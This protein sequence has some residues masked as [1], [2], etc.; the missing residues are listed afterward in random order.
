M[1]YRQQFYFFF[2][3]S[4]PHYRCSHRYFIASLLTILPVIVIV[5]VVVLVVLLIKPKR[6]ITQ[7]KVMRD[8]TTKE[9]T[10]RNPNKNLLMRSF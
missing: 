6:T 10:K 9:S 1:I 8:S 5:A 4:N 7:G 3:N 2:S